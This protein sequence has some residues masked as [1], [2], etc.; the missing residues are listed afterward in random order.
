MT[1]EA[2]VFNQ[3]VRER[4]ATGYGAY[5]KKRKGGRTIRFPSDYLSRRERQQMN[6]EVFSFDPRKFYTAEEFTAL[7]P[8]YKAKLI[9]S[10]M[11]K[12]DVGLSNISEIV[13][14][15]S[16]CWLYKCLQTENTLTLLEKMTRRRHKES[17]KLALKADCEAY[18]GGEA[19]AKEPPT[20]VKES[21]P[22]VNNIAVLLMKLAGTGA[23]I[24]IEFTL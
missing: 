8:V 11:D 3:T 10:Y 22:D 20:A 5:H 6:G 15:K 19:K 24:T 16:K 4:K 23:K 18:R 9:N 7:P 12:Y 14:G 2:F 13:F 17:G 21:P 1:D